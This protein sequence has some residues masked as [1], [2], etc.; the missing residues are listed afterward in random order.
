MPGGPTKWR[1][2]LHPGQIPSPRPSSER[3]ERVPGR[4]DPLRSKRV[5][6]EAGA[7]GNMLGTFAK[8]QQCPAGLEMSATRQ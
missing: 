6:V 2:V 1:A 3:R 5:G 7:L 8:G 4:A